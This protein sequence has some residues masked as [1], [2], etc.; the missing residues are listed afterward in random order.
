MTVELDQPSTVETNNA[1]NTH[2][3]RTL[4]YTAIFVIF[5]AAAGYF[6]ATQPNYEQQ[7]VVKSYNR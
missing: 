7:S 1:M 6:I 3:V 5:V 4:G 2:I